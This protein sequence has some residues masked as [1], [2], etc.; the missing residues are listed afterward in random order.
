M[1]GGVCERETE[2]MNLGDRISP[3]TRNRRVRVRSLAVR[4]DSLSVCQSGLTAN[5]AQCIIVVTG[6]T[7]HTVTR[8]KVS[9]LKTP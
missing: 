5:A 1:R 6:L 9:R 4:T 8:T 2:R 3:C 7:H